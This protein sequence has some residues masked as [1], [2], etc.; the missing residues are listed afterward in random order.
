MRNERVGEPSQAPAEAWMMIRMAGSKCAK[1]SGAHGLAKSVLPDDERENAQKPLLY[2]NAKIE[3]VQSHRHAH[4]RDTHGQAQTQAHAY[5]D[6]D[7]YTRT[8]TQIY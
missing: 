5:T 4:T 7:T 6:E 8:R 3:S 1:R 2:K